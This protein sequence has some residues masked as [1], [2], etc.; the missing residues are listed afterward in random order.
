LL[1]IL[2]KKYEFS[3]TRI[4]QGAPSKQIRGTRAAEK[5]VQKLDGRLYTGAH[6][7]F[8][9]MAHVHFA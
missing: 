5:H 3:K 6:V 2:H 8:N 7:N 1:Q 4:L 9:Q